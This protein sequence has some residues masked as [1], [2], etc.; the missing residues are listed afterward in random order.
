MLFTDTYRTISGQAT[1]QFKDRG[2][3]FIGMVFPVRSE[4]EIKNQLALLKKEYH[5]AR[6]H[7]YAYILGPDKSA[8]RINDDGEP[9]GSAGRPIYNTL[10]SNDLT[11][12]L[13]V[14]IRYF[15]GVKLGVPGLIHAYK[16]ATAEAL[17]GSD[18]VEKIVYEAY[19]IDYDY[20]VMNDIMKIV[21]EHSVTVI[22]SAFDLKC[23]ITALIR[24]RDSESVV[25]SFQQIDGTIVKYLYLE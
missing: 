5:D 3:R 16:T 24:R 2:S 6:H 19:K 1:G 8:Y 18:I 21:K 7:C 12:V 22:E 10:L 23:S 15:G 13:A 17:G 25:K 14:V 4:E 20:P 9:S 11:N